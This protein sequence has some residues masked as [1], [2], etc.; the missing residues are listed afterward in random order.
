MARN[1]KTP[2]IADTPLAQNLAY[3]FKHPDS[4]H[5]YR[6]SLK[7]FEQ[8]LQNLSEEIKKRYP[9]D[10]RGH[11]KP[12]SIKA[13]IVGRRDPKLSSV[14]KIAVAYYDLY[15]IEIDHFDLFV[16]KNNWINMSEINPRHKEICD[17]MKKIK[18]EITLT[19]IES[20]V[21]MGIL[22]EEEALKRE[23]L[24]EK[25]ADINSDEKKNQRNE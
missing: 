11:M 8:E 4:N 7:G 16:N 10:K 20:L 23:K 15:G 18:N 24:E 2:S 14:K 21:D 19:A 13:I 6:H 12:S 22:K 3:L 17:K 1:R 5:P 25:L 9:D